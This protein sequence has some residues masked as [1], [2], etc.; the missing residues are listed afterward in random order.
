MYSHMYASLYLSLCIVTH[1]HVRMYKYI[2]I[3]IYIYVWIDIRIHE[4]RTLT[5]KMGS[6]QDFIFRGGWS[7]NWDEITWEPGVPEGPV[8]HVGVPMA[9]S[10][11]SHGGK[12]PL[13]RKRALPERRGNTKL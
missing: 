6:F 9:P 3:Y 4:G 1:A 7:Q 10:E 12:A 8:L 5:S 2:Y 13:G 11:L